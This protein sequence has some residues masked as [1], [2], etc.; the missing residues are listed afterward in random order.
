MNPPDT[1]AF[2]RCLLAGGVALLP[3]DTVYGLAASPTAPGGVEKIFLLKRRPA[4][5]NLPVMVASV[6]DARLLGI[7]VNRTA[8]ALFNSEYMPG[9]LTVVAGFG[10]ASRPAWLA[11]RDEVAVRIPDEPFML[12]LL[13]RT[14][15]LLVTSANLHGK[16]TRETPQEIL[17]ELDGAPDMALDLGERE[18]IPSTIVNSRCDPPKVERHGQVP[19]LEIERILKCP[20]AN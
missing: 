13:R 11:G 7:D 4:T 20:L 16:A 3:T 19:A 8:S 12:E 17:S 9:P 18:I 2:A 6:E 15:P 5:L 10:A 1:E 14:G